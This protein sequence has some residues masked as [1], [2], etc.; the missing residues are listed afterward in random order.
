MN[1]TRC[2]VLLMELHDGA[3]SYHD[4]METNN[5][6]TAC[7]HGWHSVASKLENLVQGMEGLSAASS[8]LTHDVHREPRE[9]KTHS[10][11]R[12]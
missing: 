3:A 1:Q 5:T 8:D 12:M 10:F 9:V 6:T 4:V 2:A 7:T 11:K